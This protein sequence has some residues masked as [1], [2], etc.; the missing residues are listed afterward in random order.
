MLRHRKELAGAMLKYK[1]DYV[2]LGE[3][4]AVLDFFKTVGLLVSK[5]MIDT[6]IV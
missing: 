2:S 3:H 5:K 6:N 1:Q 4:E